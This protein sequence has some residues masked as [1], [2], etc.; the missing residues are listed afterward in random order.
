MSPNYDNPKKVKSK[1]I[2]QSSTNNQGS[3]VSL[4]PIR[5]ENEE[6]IENMR[7]TK[8][9]KLAKYLKIKEQESTRHEKK[10]QLKK[11]TLDV[12]SDPNL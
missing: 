9:E 7:K 8:Y 11:T 2:S 10:P 1:K 4:S 5:Q 12:K 3:E 6:T